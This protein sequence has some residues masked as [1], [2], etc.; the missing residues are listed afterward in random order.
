MATT[1]E[2][3]DTQRPADIE[4]QHAV[5]DVQIPPSVLVLSDSVTTL[6]FVA[7]Q[8]TV[9]G[10]ADIMALSEALKYQPNVGNQA[11]GLGHYCPTWPVKYVIWGV[12]TPD[13]WL[14]G[15]VKL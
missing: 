7:L 14:I 12:L 4:Q 15:R 5:P 13:Q 11:M 8:S 2:V 10:A 6:A 3:S 9:F 1:V